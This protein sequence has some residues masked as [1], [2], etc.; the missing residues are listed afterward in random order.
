[1]NNARKSV[2]YRISNGACQT[3]YL[4]VD[5]CLVSVVYTAPAGGSIVAG[6]VIVPPGECPREVVVVSTVSASPTSST[7]TY[8][9][10]IATWCNPTTGVAVA[11]MTLWD[12]VAVPGTAPVVTAWNLDGTAYVGAVSALVKCATTDIEVVTLTV[13]DGTSNFTRTTF[14]DG[15][16]RVVQ[17]MLWQDATGAVVATPAGPF[18]VGSCPDVTPRTIGVSFRDLAIGTV[19]TGAALQT[20][21][22]ATARLLSVT[23]R[24]STGTGSVTGTDGGSVALALGES[25]S[26]TADSAKAEDVLNTGFSFSSGSGTMR[27]VATYRG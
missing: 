14:L 8:D 24:Q 21:L 7:P 10:E 9:R 4:D 11:V 26:W 6:A 16:T 25:W 13:C 5:D 1:M 27:V 15:V 3:G 12:V 20:S 18:T 23:V 2:T 17:G 19:L 22:G